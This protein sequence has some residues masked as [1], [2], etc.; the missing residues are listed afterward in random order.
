MS[1]LHDEH[2]VAA[3][4]DFL[5]NRAGDLNRALLPL[6]RDHQAAPRL[7]GAAQV[8][9][10]LRPSTIRAALKQSLA[11]GTI[12][13]GDGE[14][15]DVP[16]MSRP[17]ADHAPMAADLDLWVDYIHAYLAAVSYADAKIGQVLD[18]L[19]AD[20][21][22]AA[23]TAIV[24]WSDNGFHLGDHNRWQKF[25]NWREATEVP[26]IVVDPDRAA[27]R[28]R[29]RSSA[30]STSSRPCS[31]SW[32][33]TSRPAR[34]L[35]R[36]P[37]ADRRGHRHRLVQSRQRPGGRADRRLGRSRSAPVVPG[38]G[39]VRYTRYPDGRRRSTSSPSTPTSTSTASNY[40]T[41]KGLTA[42]DDALHDMSGT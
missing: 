15:V 42:A 21:A 3:A 20:P 41:G 4:L 18:A 39:D 34:P 22:L 10:A 5:E 25:T 11:D 33:S 6:G 9:R 27:G 1:D 16:P 35:R 23:E 24:L 8:L 37:R 26:L 7:V 36:E 12:I 40:K 2:T 38:Y 14:Y 30:S 19:E 17:S 31:T 29:S 13:P 32:A 28:S